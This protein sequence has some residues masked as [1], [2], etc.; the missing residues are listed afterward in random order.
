MPYQGSSLGVVGLTYMWLGICAPNGHDPDPDPGIGREPFQRHVV[1][2]ASIFF[3]QQVPSV[4]TIDIFF[5]DELP[6]ILRE[7]T[8]ERCLLGACIC[9]YPRRSIT[10]LGLV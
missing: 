9:R 5:L 3:K 4:N 2:L 7:T 8:Y 1:P 10:S 6:S